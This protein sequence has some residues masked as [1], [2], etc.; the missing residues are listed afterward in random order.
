MRSTPLQARLRELLEEEWAQFGYALY[1][2]R[3]A[4]DLLRLG[5]GKHIG[6]SLSGLASSDPGYLRC[7][8]SGHRTPTQPKCSSA[9][10]PSVDVYNAT[11]PI[12]FG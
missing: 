10:Y 4:S 12:R 9:T 6:T 11:R 2:D 5:F 7:T 1:T 3:Q 8:A